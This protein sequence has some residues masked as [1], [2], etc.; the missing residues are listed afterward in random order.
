MAELLPS[1]KPFCLRGRC[2]PSSPA[3]SSAPSLYYAKYLQMRRYWDGQRQL[4]I[5]S[6]VKERN[7]NHVAVEL[8]PQSRSRG[9]LALCLQVE[10]G[11]G[12]TTLPSSLCTTAKQLSGIACIFISSTNRFECNTFMNSWSVSDLVRWILFLS[13]PQL[14]L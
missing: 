7:W 11:L 1:H 6:S 9:L 14:L 2:S 10:S 4:L 8:E 3:L 13:T 5:L 12:W